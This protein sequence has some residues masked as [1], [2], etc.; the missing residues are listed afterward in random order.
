MEACEQ[1]IENYFSVSYIAKIFN[2]N[3]KTTT[4]V[5]LSGINKQKLYIYK[6]ITLYTYTSDTM[7]NVLWSNI[8]EHVMCTVIHCNV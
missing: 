5:V 4:N 2:D 6:H 7:D 8:L 1:C 3:F